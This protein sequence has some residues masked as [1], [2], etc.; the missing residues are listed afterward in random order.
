MNKEEHFIR[1]LTENQKGLYA[2]IYTMIGDHSK[3]ND[4]LQEANI[5]MW[6]KLKDF[7]GSNFNAWAITICKFQVMAFFRDQKRDRLTLNPNLHEL[8]SDTA[9]Q[10]SKSFNLRDQKLQECLQTLT[11]HNRQ[12]IEMRYFK[13][14]RINDISE[15]VNKKVSA[16]KVSIHRI[17]KSLSLCIENKMKLENS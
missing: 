14:L 12:L 8:I 10:E 5:V 13:K 15:Q 4:V 3:A 1:Q 11:A 16:V 9:E 7:D 2:Y 6:R 17:R